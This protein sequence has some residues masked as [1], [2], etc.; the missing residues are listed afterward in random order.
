MSETLETRVKRNSPD[1]YLLTASLCFLEAD[2]GRASGPAPRPAALQGRGLDRNQ[3]RGG[4]Q[5]AEKEGG[6]RREEG[7]FTELEWVVRGVRA[8][9]SILYFVFVRSPVA[10]GDKPSSSAAVPGQW[11]LT[12]GM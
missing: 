11:R 4:R 3:A 5:R 12:R 7:G 8:L 2:L 6:E 9:S 10:G 1:W